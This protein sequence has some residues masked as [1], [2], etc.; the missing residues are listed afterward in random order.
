MHALVEQQ[1]TA[2]CRTRLVGHPEAAASTKPV[3]EVGDCSGQ[4]PRSTE[5]LAIDDEAPEGPPLAVLLRIKTEMKAPVIPCL[6]KNTGEILDAV[7]G[8]GRSIGDEHNVVAL[9][10]PEACPPRGRY[11]C[12]EKNSIICSG[13]RIGLAGDAAGRPGQT[14]SN[15]RRE[16]GLPLHCEERHERHEGHEQA[17]QE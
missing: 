5:P 13:H 16:D 3:C 14:G 10:H 8:T 4:Q 9:Q 17:R 11:E 2:V 6:V 7:S 12:I 15:Q 1:V